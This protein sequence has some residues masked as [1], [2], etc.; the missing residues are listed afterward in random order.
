MPRKF[1]FVSPGI[2]V[3]EIDESIIE[4]PVTDDGLL[5]IGR[6]KAGPAMQPTKIKSLRDFVAVFGDPISGKGTANNDVWR[7]GNNQSATYGAYAA[8]AWLA[9]ETSPVTFVRL[10]GQDADNQASGYIKAGWNLDGANLTADTGTHATNVTAYGLFIMPSASATVNVTGT[11]AAVIYATGAA[12][13]LSGT[14]AGGLKNTINSSATT[15]SA[16]CMIESISTGGKGNTFTLEIRDSYT[17]SS[18]VEKHVFHLDPDQKDNYIRN[19]LNTNPLKTFATNYGSANAKK[20][21]LGETYEEAVQALV[22]GSTAGAQYGVILPLVSGSSNMVTH[23]AAATPAKSGWIINRDPTPQLNSSAFDASQLKKLFRVVSL[24][25][26]E[27]FQA[28]YYV[29]IEDLKLGTV[30]NPNSSF[31]LS[32]RKTGQNGELVEQFS[33]CNLDESSDSFVGK[34]IGDMSQTWNTTNMVFD[35]SGDYMNQSDYIRIEMGDDWKSGIDDSYMLPWGFFGPVRPKG[36]TMLEGSTGVQALPAAGVDPVDAGVVATGQVVYTSDHPDAGALLIFNHP[37]GI[38][39]EIESYAGGG[40]YSAWVANGLKMKW[41]IDNTVATD[42]GTYAAQ[43]AVA[44]NALEGYTAGNSTATVTV[45]AVGPGAHYTWTW[46]ESG[47]DTNRQAPGVITAGTDTSNLA[48]VYVKG[49]NNVI[50]SGGDAA[51]FAKMPTIMSAS[52]HFPRLKLTEENTNKASANYKNTDMF[53][54]RHKFAS[55]NEKGVAPKRDYLDLTRF[56]GGSMDVHTTAN[57][58]EYSFVFSMDEIARDAN[59]LYYWASGSHTIAIGT[60]TRAVTAGSGSQQLIDDKVRQFAVPMFGGFDGVDITKADPFS[61][62]VALASKAESTSYAFNSVSRAIDMCNTA[63]SVKYDV[64]SIPGL[65]NESL[66]NDLIRMVEERA[67]ALAIIDL[68]DGYLETYENNGTRTGGTL[69]SVKSN[70][71]S[72]DYNTSYAATYF[73]R[74]RMRDSLSGNGD[75]VIAPA[76]VAAIGALAFS[77]SDTGA[78]WF[79]P[80]GFNRGGLSQ[81]G[82]SEGPKVIGAFKQLSKSNRDELYQRNINPVARFPAIGETVI[83]GQK[84]LQQTKSALDRINVRR[85]MIF[86]KKRVG[87]VAE[88]VLFDQNVQATWSRFK[89]GADLILR[90]AQSRLGITEYQLVLDETTTTADL[91]DQNILYA[92]VF[93]KPARAIEFIAI[94]FIVTRSGIEF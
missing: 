31:T 74:V 72:R 40:H 88:T 37:D 87:R 14:M 48:H 16:G 30:T 36:F 67:D 13:T 50:H 1:D 70:A 8:Q 55:K 64:I 80:A 7:D 81:L 92:K 25:D 20:Y 69:A 28:N 66:T 12:V 21:F 10:L 41:R 33:N 3:E 56:Q 38:V 79:A 62:A 22:S 18:V 35:I 86:L 58:T 32:V 77:D 53:G 59:G 19:V 45:T 5:I 6:A 82:G 71:D 60:Q 34:K 65:T 63:E 43:V 57:A 90:D 52:I 73:P 39:Y 94:D 83:F 9:S 68:D 85:L 76:S 47:D 23:Q 4:A 54:V 84:T 89:A 78:P 24:H 15:S 46:S 91:V 2:S 61:S 51:Q 11:L 49:N 17:E 44:L 27:W 93:I 42:H 29:T 75:M 26:G